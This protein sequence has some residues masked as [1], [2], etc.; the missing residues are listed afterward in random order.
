MKK[1]IRIVL[2]VVL[3]VVII[4]CTVWYLFVY[5]QQFTRDMLLTFARQSEFSGN[6]HVAAWFYKAA[7]AQSSKND[8]VAIELADQY[9]RIGNYTKAEYTLSNA[10]ADSGSI[11]L[12]IA[13]CK[14]YVEQDKLLDA[15]TM[16]SNITNPETK[17][18]LEEMRP[19]AP[20]SSPAP[21]FYSQYI[22]VTLESKSGTIYYSAEGLYP[23]TENAYKEPIPLTHGENSI[24]AITVADNGLV[25]P[26]SIFGYTVGGIVE[27]V[28][29][30]DPAIEI[31]VRA[32]LGEETRVLDTSD[33]WNIKELTVPAEAANLSDLRHMAFLEKLTITN[34]PATDFSFVSSLANLTELTI[35]GTQVSQESLN[36]IGAL[37]KL[38]KLTIANCGITSI[39][40]LAKSTELV[41]LDANNNTI[42]N[43]DAL[44]NVTNLQELN[45]QHNAVTDISV[46]SG[47]TGLTILDVSYNALTTLAPVSTLTSLTK[48]DASVNKITDIGQINNLTNLQ[49][50][51]VSSNQITDVSAVSSCSAITHLDISTNLLTDVSAL[52]TLVK[53]QYFN[54]SHNKVTAIP[55]FQKDCELVTIDGS[56][57]QITNLDPLSD[58]G[59][60]NTVNMDYNAG[61]SSV[62]PLESCHVL[63]EV[64]VYGTKVKDVKGLTDQ[65][66]IVN[67]T[68]V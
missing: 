52:S 20:S 54:F 38:K 1:T 40:P 13:L 53:M 17:A 25:S 44:R 32:L 46:L 8:T 22:S 5:D 49:H 10:I 50:L 43:I 21:G 51:A 48:L 19:A 14:T 34:C 29:F 47:L 36:F 67:Y 23:T 45:L 27:E 6:Q 12:Y 24:Y 65:S 9:K 30:A 11:D 56:N 7:Y 16:L 35:S 26:L 60:L 15:V 2:P 33:L 66:I 64:N 59:K 55:E 62:K 37:P 41:Y 39:A 57:N 3:S 61:I 18:K 63:I 42:R 28:A 68:P 4:L 31:T 58:L